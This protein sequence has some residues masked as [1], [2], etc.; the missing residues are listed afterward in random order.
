MSSKHR[1][2]RAIALAGGGPAAGLHIG[3]LAALEK[4]GIG[5]DVFALSCIGAWVGIVYN[6]RPGPDRAQQTLDFFA[7]YCFRD[8]QSYDWFPVNLGFATDLQ[9]LRKA[10]QDFPDSPDLNWASLVLPQQIQDSF[11]RSIKLFTQ[12]GGVTNQE[13]NYWMLNDVLAVNPVTRYL[14]SLVYKSDINGLSRIYYKQSHVLKEVFRE[15]ALYG[16]DKPEIYHNAWRMARTEGEA[17]SMQ[18]FHN[19]PQDHQ[20]RRYLKISPKSLC[21]CSALPYIEQ[22]VRIGKDE[23]TEGALVDTVNF[24]N[25]LRDHPDLDEVW[26]NRIVDESQV[27]TPRDLAGALANLPM[28]F[29][30]EVGE[31]DIKLFRQHLLNQSRMGP[32]VVEV[33]IRPRTKVS[34]EWKHSNLMQGFDE[35]YAAV[36]QLLASDHQLRQSTIA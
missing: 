24:R 5:F 30:A 32:R 15:R 34:F 22:S 21:A 27:R 33:P 31:N 18:I 36:N 2:K 12:P 14:T 29:A 28:Q 3:A 19:R 25:V 8:D 35:G 1:K 16:D 4:A 9:A 26:V 13:F 17:G 10:W 6:T 7:T 23:Y 20:G 11:V